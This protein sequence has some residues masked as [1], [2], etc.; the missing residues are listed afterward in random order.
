MRDTLPLTARNDDSAN[1]NF[2]SSSGSG[3]H[4]VCYRK[5]RC[6]VFYLNSFDNLKPPL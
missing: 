6:K 4:W 1:V 3:T 2:D 5:V